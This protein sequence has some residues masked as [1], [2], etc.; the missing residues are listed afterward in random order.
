MVGFAE[1]IVALYNALEIRDQCPDCGGNGYIHVWAGHE[2]GSCVAEACECSDIAVYAL[3]RY[4]PQYEAA[5]N[6]YLC[7]LGVDPDEGAKMTENLVIR[8]FAGVR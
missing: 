4:K 5:V 2:N 1:A 3:K 6:R 7:E 8:L